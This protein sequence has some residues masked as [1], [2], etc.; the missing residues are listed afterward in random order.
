MIKQQVMQASP[1]DIDEIRE[2]LGGTGIDEGTKR[3][4]KKRAEKTI[5]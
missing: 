5:T 4:K 3:S 2:E 1:E